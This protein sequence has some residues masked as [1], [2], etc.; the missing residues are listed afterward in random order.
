MKPV[1]FVVVLTGMAAALAATATR[2]ATGGL[3]S[4]S[5]A[6]SDYTENCG[7]CHGFDGDSEPADIP[8]LKDRV[9]YFMCTREGR[10]YLIRLP[11]VAHSRITDPQE[12]ADLVNFVV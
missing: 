4:M 3:M 8:V 10:D 9:G 5:V 6:Q 12:L 2:A 11:N 7:G 1:A